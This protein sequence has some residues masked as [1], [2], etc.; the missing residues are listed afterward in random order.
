M[1]NKQITDVCNY[2]V[3]TASSIDSFPKK[4]KLQKLSTLFPF[5]KCFANKG[6]QGIAGI[7]KSKHLKDIL[8]VFKINCNMDYAIEHE[9]ELL[10]QLNSIK[11]WCPNFVSILG[12][13]TVPIS[14]K[15]IKTEKEQSSSDEESDSSSSE[16]EVDNTPISIWEND[17]EYSN[18]IMILLE[19]IGDYSLHHMCRYGSVQ[20]S[21]SQII[22]TL[23][24]LYIAQRDLEFVHYDMHLD[25]IM[26]KECDENIIFVYKLN[27]EEYVITPTLGHY[28]MII[29]MGSSYCKS[30]IGTSVKT[31][32]AFYSSGQQSTI[33]DPLNDVHHFLF[34]CLDRLETYNDR[35]RDVGT[36]FMNIFRFLPIWRFKGWKKLPNN[37]IKNIIK[38]MY[39][40]CPFISDNEFW[41]DYM[42]ELMDIFAITTS[43]QWKVEQKFLNKEIL[44]AEINTVCTIISK[45]IT[46]C[47]DYDDFKN[48]N[49]VLLLIK[50]ISRYSLKPT[51]LDKN[52]E[53][54]FKAIISKIV[55]K[56]PIKL[57]VILFATSIKRIG[58]ILNHLLALYLKDNTDV[59]EE[60]YS[61]TIIKSPLDAIK[62]LQKMIPCR[63][64]ITT[65]TVFKV[66]DSVKKT[67]YDILA[68]KLWNTDKNGKLV[69]ENEL[70][71]YQLTPKM[72]QIVF[73]KICKM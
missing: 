21:L 41:N 2:I 11:D 42:Y 30:L 46:I 36:K 32:I 19:Y 70:H 5:Q 39:E 34:R 16:E 13:L 63:H 35:W 53:S 50:E 43:I 56:L 22:M 54:Q 6:V 18:E 52:E 66:F 65:K 44:E 40:I 68:N 33:F 29:D 31:S 67:T 64:V 10:Y 17:K 23:A 14:S 15:F 24:G 27:N 57:D 12:E 47:N 69:I 58:I 38:Y 71:N 61:K 7:I 28:P 20:Q 4:K 45:Y 37:I 72:K 9:K 59:I 73:D 48:D 8:L 60:A 55:G 51:Y 25:N 3:S 49:D 26:L 62:I 1:N